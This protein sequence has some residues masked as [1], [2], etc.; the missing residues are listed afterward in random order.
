M[1]FT[2]KKVFLGLQFLWPILGSF[3]TEVSLLISAVATNQLACVTPPYGCSPLHTYL[4]VGPAELSEPYF[5]VNMHVFKS[6]EVK[7]LLHSWTTY[8]AYS[9]WNNR[10]KDLTP[11]KLRVSVVERELD[12]FHTW[13]EESYWNGDEAEINDFPYTTENAFCLYKDLVGIPDG[14][15]K[16]VLSL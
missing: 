15:E 16:S 13:D 2:P 6:R 3:L 4:G 5:W 9:S 8:P 7:T 10:E 14:L 1:G 12:G 11:E